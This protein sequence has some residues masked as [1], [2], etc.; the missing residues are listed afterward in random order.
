MFFFILYTFELPKTLTKNYNSHNIYSC[1]PKPP[2]HKILSLVLAY[3]FLEEEKAMM[4][5]SNTDKADGERDFTALL[6]APPILR[7][8]IY[9]SPQEDEIYVSNNSPYGGVDFRDSS[10][11]E[12]SWQSV[13]VANEG[14]KWYADTKDNDK[15]CHLYNGCMF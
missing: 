1:H 7:D 11:D 12:E 14:W 15:V 8:P 9:L 3:C 2:G 5:L 10:K 13:V 4:S 6:D